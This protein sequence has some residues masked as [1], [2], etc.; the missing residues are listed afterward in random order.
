M[1]I[2]QF[3][4]LAIFFTICLLRCMWCKGLW[5][6]FC[7]YC[8]PHIFAKN[9][10]FFLPLSHQFFPLFSLFSSF[11][12]MP[13]MRALGG[14]IAGSRKSVQYFWFSAE[15]HK[16]V[17]VQ[18]ALAHYPRPAARALSIHR[19]GQKDRSSGNKNVSFPLFF[20]TNVTFHRLGFRDITLGPE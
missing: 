20:L 8:I 19:P 7:V 3:Q 10:N 4:W 12:P 1:I 13:W 11:W 17:N 5:F 16:F 18:T 2:S 15:P 6:T 9:N 14:T